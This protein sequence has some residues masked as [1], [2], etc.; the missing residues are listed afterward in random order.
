MKLQ[1]LPKL[2]ETA[3]VHDGD[4]IAFVTL[5]VDENTENPLDWTGDQIASVVVGDRRCFSPKEFSKHLRNRDCVKLSYYR[6]SDC[7]WYVQGEAPAG[8]DCPWDSVHLAGLWVP[9]ESSLQELQQVSKTKGKNR[10]AKALA[11]A[12]ASCALYSAWS[13][14]EVYGYDVEVYNALYDDEELVTDR[15]RY[16]RSG[17]VLVDESC[18]GFYLLNSED[19][20]DMLRDINDHLK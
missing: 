6:H 5:F 10:R 20:K 7:L 18:G 4:R 17:D 2:N 11:L 15:Q 13:N 16:A 19:E 3:H 1:E 14:G 12:R 8:A 9:G